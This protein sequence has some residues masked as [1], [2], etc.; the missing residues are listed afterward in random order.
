MYLTWHYNVP[1][2]EIT[3]WNLVWL[4][5]KYIQGV[6]RSPS[7]HGYMKRKYWNLSGNVKN[8]SLSK[9]SMLYPWVAV[10]F[11]VPYS[12]FPV[13][14]D[15]P[16]YCLC[17]MCAH[18]SEIKQNIVLVDKQIQSIRSCSPTPIFTYSWYWAD[19]YTV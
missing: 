18:L 16:Y 4:L 7:R 8:Y 11:T 3:P 13:R 6:L 2:S 15:M 5:R 12:Q 14:P 9:F 10:I 19:H 1:K 17:V